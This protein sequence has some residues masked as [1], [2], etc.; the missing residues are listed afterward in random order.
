M[1][2]ELGKNMF[3]KTR[4]FFG[5]FLA[6]S[7]AISL[8]A[9]PALPK[10]N[11]CRENIYHELYKIFASQ[12]SQTSPSDRAISGLAT[13]GMETLPKKPTVIGTTAPSTSAITTKITQSRCV[14]C[15]ICAQREA[16]STKPIA[17]DITVNTLEKLSIV[18][19]PKTDPKYTVLSK[20][21][22]P[23]ETVFGT[24]ARAELFM[25]L[26]S[27]TELQDNQEVTKYF[28]EHD[29]IRRKALKAIE[30]IRAAQNNF[31]WLFLVEEQKKDRFENYY[32][33]LPGLKKLN[34]NSAGLFFGDAVEQLFKTLPGLTPPCAYQGMF[35]GFFKGLSEMA[36]KQGQQ[37]NRTVAGIIADIANIPVATAKGFGQ[38]IWGEIIGHSPY[39]YAYKEEQEIEESRL[40]FWKKK[41]A[42]SKDTIT[43]SNVPD[44]QFTS[45]LDRV[46][47]LEASISPSDPS[48]DWTSAL[49][50]RVLNRRATPFNTYDARK[51]KIIKPGVET[52]RR[53]PWRGPAVSWTLA[54]GGLALYDVMNYA[55]AKTTYKKLQEDL[56]AFKLAQT[57]LMSVARI[58]EGLTELRKIAQDSHIKPLEALA[59][60]LIAFEKARKT[61]KN[62]A[63]LC[64]LLE[65]NTFKGEASVFSNRARIL[66][67]HRLLR[68]CK[69][70]FLPA[71]Q[72]EGKIEIFVSAAEFYAKHQAGTPVCFVEFVDEKEPRL[73]LENSWNILVDEQDAIG[74]DAIKFGKNDAQHAIFSG[75]NGTGKSTNENAIAHTIFMGRLGIACASRAVM[76][77]FDILAVHRNEQENIE[78]GDS[79]FMAQ[80][81]RF[82]EICAGIASLNDKRMIIFMDEP[83]NGTVEEEAG[84]IIYEKCQELLAHQ[85]Q[86]ICVIATHAEQPTRLEAATGGVF[87]NYYVEVL[88]PVF[89]EFKRTYRLLPGIP[90]WWF[91]DAER[92]HRFIDWLSLEREKVKKD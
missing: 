8:R 58:L 20:L 3:R 89:G 22:I 5:V 76:T 88:E 71:L 34:N 7:L 24:V 33:T 19:P 83:L 87:A 53:A 43:L 82:D 86:A 18:A 47:Y 6:T 17:Q 85:K 78:R 23:E 27:L 56:T 66:L 16:L 28:A 62:F 14:Y 81:A 13:I 4:V 49:N 15:D 61:D 68:K 38:G 30:K 46:S 90:C 21:A 73:E 29:A 2:G 11:I 1:A 84:R 31:L 55:N 54:L 52:F 48:S 26:P 39:A 45:L 70:L 51:E 40:Y 77:P 92:R 63:K 69:K 64:S 32:W 36:P 10:E 50:I 42:C 35:I 72:S 67:A 74:I 57:R 44:C 75:P 91:N 59:K 9:E 60:E 25:R 79:S 65:T 37:D 12:L 80:K 41:V